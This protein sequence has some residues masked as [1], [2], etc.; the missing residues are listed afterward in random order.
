MDGR[1][2]VRFWTDPAKKTKR[3]ILLEGFTGKGEEGATLRLRGGA[4]AS[5][6]ASP[7]DYE[8]VRIGPYKFIQYRSGAKELYHL[9]KDRYELHSRHLDPRYREVK[10]WLSKLLSHLEHC[11]ARSCKRQVKQDP[12]AAAQAQAEAQARQAQAPTGRL[13]LSSR[14]AG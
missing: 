14:P 11:R 10:A 5:I 6:K 8:G 4:H 1:S 13:G 3:P 9:A 2:L 7:R 12:Q